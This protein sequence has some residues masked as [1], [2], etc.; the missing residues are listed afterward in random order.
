MEGKRCVTSRPEGSCVCPCL[1]CSVVGGDQLG[2]DSETSS[3]QLEEEVVAVPQS[4]SDAEYGQEE[5]EEEEEEE[6]EGSEGEHA[7]YCFI[8]KDGGQLLCCDHCP[9]AYHLSCLVPPLKQIPKGDWSCPR[10]RVSR[11]PVQRLHGNGV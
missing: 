9:L 6:M 5:D 2:D 10:C 8:C 7:D 4:A 1:K 3:L 11:R